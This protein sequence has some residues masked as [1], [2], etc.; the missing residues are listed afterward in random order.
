MRTWFITGTSR[1]F[2]REMTEILLGRGDRVAA[3][4]R[5]PSRLDELADRHTDRLWRAE[6]DVTDTARMREV[7]RRA[8]ADLGRIDVVVSN[9]GH[10]LIGLAE[11]LTDEQIRRQ[12]DTNVTAPI[13]LVRAVTPHLREQGGGRI[14][15]TSSMGGHIAYPALSLYHASKWAIEGFFEAYAQEV[16][17]FGIR[18]TLIEPGMVATGFY[19]SADVAPSELAAYAGTQAAAFTHGESSVALR[20]MP[21]DPRKVAQAMIRIGV[22]AD[23]PRRQLLGSDAYRLVHDALHARLSAV[24]AQ[25]P[26]AMTTDRDDLTAAG[27]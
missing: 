7:V 5:D 20:D 4:L 26:I 1:G 8:F 27:A 9:A 6:L 19:A 13:Q 2:G 15:Q 17:P 23:P 22:H 18:T 3:T 10:G 24:R 11:E 14:L 16:E 25:R 21:G 12:L